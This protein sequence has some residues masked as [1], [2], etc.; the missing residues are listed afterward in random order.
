[1][2]WRYALVIA[3]L[4]TV[5]CTVGQDFDPPVAAVPVE[6]Q[7]GGSSDGVETVDVIFDVSAV[8]EREQPWWQQFN[9]P[10]LSEL[11]EGAIAGNLRVEIAQA[12]L[13]EARAIRNA[14]AGRLLPTVGASSTAGRSRAS[15]RGPGPL[16][17]LAEAGLASLENEQYTVGFDTGWELDLFGGVR[18]GRE[19]SQ[20]R[21]EATGE[22][23]RAMLLAVAAEVA[24]AYTDH[25][26]A[27]LRLR[28]ARRNLEIQEDTSRVIEAK[29]TSGLVPLIDLERTRTLKASLEAALAPLRV[30]RAAAAHRLAT[31][32]GLLP[33]QLDR[34]LQQPGEVPEPPPAIASGLPADLLLRRPDLRAAERELHA[35]TAD[36]GAAVADRF[37]KISIGGSFGLES[38]RLSDL[39]DSAA[40]AWAF[41]PSL[42]LPIFQGGRLTAQ[43]AA[44]RSRLEVAEAR[45]KLSVLGA[46]EEVETGLVAYE[47]SKLAQGAL[48]DAAESS[49]K[50]SELAGVLYE[51][52]LRDHLVLLDAQRS[53]T[54]IEDSLALARINTARSAI[55]LY[56]ALGGG[57]QAL[58]AQLEPS[59]EELN[60][61]GGTRP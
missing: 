41:G 35:S 61:P 56:K 31:L 27:E 19:A 36:I 12:R 28:L 8:L 7:Q 1:M 43:V 25:R 4:S 20:A 45:W 11:I 33:G 47:Q 54:A 57:W 44:A 18:R 9:E 15:A 13:E 21:F 22:N 58:E 2:S 50:T 53:Q 59:G 52:G 48:S 40:H 5:G 51:L 42:S 49:A 3:L 39:F 24:E 37:P 30:Q 38:A 34:L 29:V 10:V 6:Y 14:R 23:L 60:G 46:L 17:S 55:Q 32:S 16:G 26:G